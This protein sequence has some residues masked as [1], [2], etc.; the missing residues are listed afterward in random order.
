MAHP[1]KCTTLPV[2]IAERKPRF[3]SNPMVTDPSTVG[4]AIRNIGQKDFK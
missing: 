1:V 4:T 3:P 2:Q